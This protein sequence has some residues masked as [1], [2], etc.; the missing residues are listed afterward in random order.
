[1]KPNIKVTIGL[2]VK[3]AAATVGQAVDSILNQDFPR[4]LMELIVVDGCSDDGTLDIVKSR[5]KNSGIEARIFCE[6]EGLG[7]A[8]QIVVDNA[9]SDYIIWVDSDMILSKDFVSKQVMFM[10]KNPEVG[11][12]KGKYGI[13]NG[14]NLVATLEDIEFAINV[15]EK[16]QNYHCI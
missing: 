7:R 9:Q 5:L 13:Q 1:M 11:I 16:R 14:N 2:C 4:E 15:N 10:E 12:A 6:S 3:N 8:R